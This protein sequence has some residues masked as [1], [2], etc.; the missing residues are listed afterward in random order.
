M[1]VPSTNKIR[2]M[3]EHRW[4]RCEIFFL[5]ERVRLNIA[6]DNDDLR[7]C[8]C[9]GKRGYQE[10]AHIVPRSLGGSDD[11]TNL[12]LLCGECHAAS[13]DM[14]FPG[15]FI[16]WV[17]AES[18]RQYQIEM[19][20][21]NA[22]FEGMIYRIHGPDE[23][24]ERLSFLDEAMSAPEL[25]VSLH[26]ADLVN[27]TRRARM[28][29]AGEA[30]RS[31]VRQRWPDRVTEQ[32]ARRAEAEATRRRRQ[33]EGIARARAAG[34]YKGKPRD[35]IMRR[36]VADLLEEGNSIRKAAEIARV[37]PA[38]VQSVKREGV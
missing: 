7:L 22:L 20:A 26:S 37:S 23:I 38:T 4:R 15:A 34:K 16:D 6:D 1:A 32:E 11:S 29:M 12:F 33:A 18:S 19:E 9:C 14:A 31:K 2:N 10:K 28:S 24:P 27:S 13:P 17:N 8:W 5:G 25:A 35:T 36:H 30:V 3:W 21:F